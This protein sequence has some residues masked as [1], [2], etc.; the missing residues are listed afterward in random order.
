MWR[1]HDVFEAGTFVYPDG[2][3]DVGNQVVPGSRALPDGEIITGSPNPALV[4]MPTLPMAPLPAYAQIQ[5][6]VTYEGVPIKFGGQIVFGGKCLANQING[7]DVIGG[8]ADGQT[9]NGTVINSQYDGTS[10]RARASSYRRTIAWESRI[11][12]LHS[13]SCR[14]ARAASAA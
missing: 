9:L 11:S 7:M 10:K 13:R 2:F 12:V 5:N 8:C 1:T 6:D 3:K 4:P 14:R